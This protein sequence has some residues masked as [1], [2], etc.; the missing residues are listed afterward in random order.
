MGEI[1]R[2]GI[3]VLLI[4]III[5]CVGWWLFDIVPSHLKVFIT[6]IITMVV[7]YLWNNAIK[8]V[9]S[10]GFINSI[11][12]SLYFTVPSIMTSILYYYSNLHP[13]QMNLV[14]YDLIWSILNYPL[15]IG[16]L[17]LDTLSGSNTNIWIKILMPIIAINIIVLINFIE[18]KIKKI[19]NLV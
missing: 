7:I 13:Y 16:N 17:V 4:Q 18:F 3:K 2:L 11:K 12:V 9:S 5:S 15:L 14:I 8:V 10:N 19:K 1:N 6:L